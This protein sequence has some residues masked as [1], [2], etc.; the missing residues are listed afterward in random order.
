M[1]KKILFLVVYK[2]WFD[3]M[4]SGVKK[5]EYRKKSKWILSRLENKTYDQIKFSN[6]YGKDKPFFICEYKGF[7]FSE[8]KEKITFNEHTIYLE[9]EDIVIRL[10]KVIEKGNF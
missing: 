8:K 6:G 3:L 2:H 5:Y 10:G 7:N 1:P 9:K 4:Y